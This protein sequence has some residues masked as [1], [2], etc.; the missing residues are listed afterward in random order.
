MGLHFGEGSELQYPD[1]TYFAL[2]PDRLRGLQ[3]QQD[4]VDDDFVDLDLTSTVDELSTADDLEYPAEFQPQDAAPDLLELSADEVV[5]S[6]NATSSLDA[7]HPDPC[8]SPRNVRV[9]TKDDREDLHKL[10]NMVSSF[11]EV[12]PFA[13]DSKTFNALV[14]APLMD[15]SGP[16]PCAVQALMQ[17]M[18]G[19]MIRHR[20]VFY[21]L[22]NRT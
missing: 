16:R 20:Y 12:P 18:E 5:A 1:E 4:V 9:W 8:P 7:Y 2:D 21:C 14:I 19:V 13:A 6:L 11:L 15:S 3:D 22:H 10:G 17:V